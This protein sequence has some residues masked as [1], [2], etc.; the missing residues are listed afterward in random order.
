M[1]SSY[2]GGERTCRGA[3]LLQKLQK[4]N[5]VRS[6]LIHQSPETDCDSTAANR[7]PG[8][9]AGICAVWEQMIGGSIH[10]VLYESAGQ[11]KYF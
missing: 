3:G 4:G 5:M 2:A 6:E 8:S 7:L 1:P 11:K 9:A 10:F